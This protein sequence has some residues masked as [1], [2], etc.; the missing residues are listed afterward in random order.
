MQFSFF[1][2]AD[3]TDI[4]NC[5]TTHSR[6][7]GDSIGNTLSR[8]I[9]IGHKWC[10][11]RIDVSGTR[12]YFISILSQRSNRSEESLHRHANTSGRSERITI[13]GRIVDQT[14]WMAIAACARH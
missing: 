5:W 13:N 6:Q 4:T 10:A 3:S 1:L 12:L 7:L 14:E 11:R 2:F 9:G 8:E